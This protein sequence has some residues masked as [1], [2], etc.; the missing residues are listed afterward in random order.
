MREPYYIETSQ[1]A[2]PQEALYGAIGLAVVESYPAGEV[3]IVGRVPGGY[4]V[5]ACELIGAAR[6]GRW[7][8][9]K[10]VG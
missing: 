9:V 8:P 10:K 5:G 4:V 7:Y 2:H 6:N 1:Y 3:R